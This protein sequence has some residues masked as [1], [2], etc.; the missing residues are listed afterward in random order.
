M[1]IHTF[2]DSHSRFGWPEDVKCNHISSILCYSFGKQKLDRVDIRNY[3][4]KEND[5]IIFCFG[6]ID[7]RCHIHKHI[8]ETMTYKNIID[9]IVDHYFEAIKLNVDISQI[10]FRN[11]CVY[12]VVPPIQ[13]HRIEENP[14]VPFLGTDEERK[15]YTTCFNEKLKEKCLEYGYIFF[16]VYDKY[17]DENKFLNMELS[18]GIVHI[19]NGIYIDEFIKSNFI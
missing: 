17:L 7:C 16:D 15:Q 12:N 6:E 1:S 4:I 8:S 14:E 2:G 13:K 19:K 3:D 5:S 18:D 10:K 11:I 9:E